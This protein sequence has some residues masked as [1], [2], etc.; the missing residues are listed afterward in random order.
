MSQYS[1]TIQH[2]AGTKHSNADGLSRIPEELDSCNCYEAGKD[3]N[4]LPCGGCPYC[5]K[6]H[7]QLSRF[8][9]E[10]HYAVPLVVMQLSGSERTDT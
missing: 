2:R 1:M 6:L 4:A 10:V 3:V 9:E 7:M 5:V 8:E